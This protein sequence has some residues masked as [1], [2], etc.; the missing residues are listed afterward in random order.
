[1]DTEDTSPS[2]KSVCF[3]KLQIFDEI[4]CTNF[5]SPV[6][7][8]HVRVLPWYTNM[9]AGKQRKHLELALATNVSTFLNTLTSKQDKN[10]ESDKYIFFDKRV[11]TFMSLTAK[12]LKFK[13]CLISDEETDMNLP[14][15]MSDEDNNLGGSYV[16]DF[17]K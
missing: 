11:Q 7:S 3:P 8:R 4:F 12:T 6:W 14:P 17:R 16:L 2:F 5:Q 15:M 10:H 13:M 1:M 9:A